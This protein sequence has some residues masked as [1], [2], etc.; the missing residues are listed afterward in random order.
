MTIYL[1]KVHVIDIKA[2][3]A[4]EANLPREADDE[5]AA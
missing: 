3:L 4:A 5:I 1:S 2:V